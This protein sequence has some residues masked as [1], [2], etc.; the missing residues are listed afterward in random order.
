REARDREP[1]RSRHDD[2]R[3]GPPPC[4]GG[5]LKT[6]TIVVVDDDAPVR[7]ALESLL[8]AAGYQVDSYA[9]AEGFLQSGRLSGADCL[10]LD[11][12]MHGMSGV[13]LLAHLDRT[14]ALIPVIFMT[15]HAATRVRKEAPSA[16]VVEFLEKPFSDDALI[17]AIERA[18]EAA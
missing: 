5:A 16:R 11:V 17:G 2:P 4:L 8:E 1:A 10:L 14:G 12:R 6:K 15:G 7:V 18:L 9:S 3:G 13:D